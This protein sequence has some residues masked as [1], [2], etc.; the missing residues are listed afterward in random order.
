M[1]GKLVGEWTQRP[2]LKIID[3]IKQKLIQR[4]G[5]NIGE[6]YAEDIARALAPGGEIEGQFMEMVQ[7]EEIDLIDEQQRPMLRQQVSLLSNKQQQ[8][9]GLAGKDAI[10]E[11][12]EPNESVNLEFGASPDAQRLSNAALQ[13]NEQ[14][15][16][17]I[18]DQVKQFVRQNSLLK[19]AK[20]IW[21]K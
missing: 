2:L 13:V 21:R 8:Q 1:R 19:D 5:E 14:R 15:F 17:E 16:S 12:D 20:N 11:D 9:R 18:E 10:M 4:I 7:N 3:S 6:E